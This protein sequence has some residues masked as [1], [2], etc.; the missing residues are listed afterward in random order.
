[1]SRW[2]PEYLRLISSSLYSNKGRHCWWCSHISPDVSQISWS[3]RHLLWVAWHTK[4]RIDFPLPGK[5]QNGRVCAL[6]VQI[7]LYWNTELS[8]ELSS[9]LCRLN[10][11]LHTPTNH[12][13]P[14]TPD[15]CE[16][17]VNV[18]CIAA[19]HYPLKFVSDPRIRM[20]HKLRLGSCSCSIIESVIS[21]SPDLIA[22]SVI[23]FSGPEF[24][25]GV[26]ILT[27]SYH[28]R[29]LLRSTYEIFFDHSTLQE[30]GQHNIFFLFFFYIYFE[31]LEEQKGDV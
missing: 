17:L 28:I 8:T 13:R 22:L 31:S 2:S 11:E 21:H 26:F 9:V 25:E 16:R 14:C 7:G 4:F 29:D 24:F 6:D 5:F 18:V 30:S 15:S 1:M 12:L 23:P 10:T 27:G 20:C 19:L 3:S